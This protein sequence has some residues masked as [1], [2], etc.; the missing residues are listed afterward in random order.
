MREFKETERD[1]REGSSEG[2]MSGI[3]YTDHEVQ[4]RDCQFGLGELDS[5]DYPQDLDADLD[6]AFENCTLD[7]GRSS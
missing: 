7:D 1:K 4:M 6:A 5:A 3:D 2:F